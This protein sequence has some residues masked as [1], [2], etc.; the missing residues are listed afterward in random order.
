MFVINEKTTSERRH[1]ILVSVTFHLLPDNFP[2]R[3]G[4]NP[5]SVTVCLTSLND[6][7]RTDWMGRPGSKPTMILGQL[8]SDHG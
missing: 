8:L 4:N 2:R 6:F 3:L 5:L 1:A 7:S